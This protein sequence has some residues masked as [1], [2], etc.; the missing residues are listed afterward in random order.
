[1]RTYKSK[2]G[3]RNYRNYCNEVLDEALLKVVS[4]QLSIRKASV[5]YNVPY[6][7]FSS[8]QSILLF[9]LIACIN[10]L[11][12]LNNIYLGKHIQRTGGQTA[13]T[14][15]EELALIKGI[16]TCADWGFPFSTIELQMFKKHYLESAGIVISKFKNNI[17]GSE[18]LKSFLK[19]HQNL[20]GIRLTQNIN[21]ARAG[22]SFETISEYFSNLYITLQD[23]PPSHI[24]NYDET[25]VSDDPGR[26]K[27]IFRRGVKYPKK[28]INHLKTPISLMI[29][30]LAS[31]VLLPPYVM[32]KSEGIMDPWRQNGSKGFPCCNDPCC[33]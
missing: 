2:L 26:K 3:K 9:L 17:L 13:S 11:G 14:E 4:G 28:V 15:K 8:T 23:I 31:G 10:S 25:N 32:Y 19:R 7:K 20:I 30:G 6:G 22:V 27:M 24:F 18:W 33:S 1:M 12:T 29:C 21:K 16:T 5:Q